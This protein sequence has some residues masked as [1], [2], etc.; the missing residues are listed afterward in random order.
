MYGRA[1][2]RIGMQRDLLADLPKLWNHVSC[3]PVLDCVI[4]IARLD[5]TP[6]ARADIRELDSELAAHAVH[7]VGP[8]QRWQCDRDIVSRA[9]NAIHY[10]VVGYHVIVARLHDSM[11]RRR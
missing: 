11:T 5:D 7:V 10:V 8:I 1:P 4:R 2:G 3:R 6:I 9:V